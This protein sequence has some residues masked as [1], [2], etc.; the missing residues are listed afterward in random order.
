M[1]SIRI[2]IL[3]LNSNVI[4]DIY[5]L[6]YNKDQKLLDIES[7][8]SF[9][10]YAFSIYGNLKN[11]LDYSIETFKTD[12]LLNEPEITLGDVMNALD[13]FK[14]LVIDL[15]TN[16][17]QYGIYVNEQLQYDFCSFLT[18]REIILRKT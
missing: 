4:T 9:V 16:L 2:I 3:P 1:S 5:S 13:N 14:S 10:L 18:E 15:H 11:T 17:L 7:V 6:K 12:F 8:L